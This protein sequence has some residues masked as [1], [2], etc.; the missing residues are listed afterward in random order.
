M[1]IEELYKQ[2]GELIT[3][4]EVSQARLKSVNERIVELLNKPVAQP[5]TAVKE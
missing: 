2:K 3:A 4:I 5:E 1:T